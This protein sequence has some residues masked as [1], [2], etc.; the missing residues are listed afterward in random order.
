MQFCN[1]NVLADL[2]PRTAVSLLPGLPAYILMMC[3]RHT[4]Y[5]NDDD[6]V[7]SLLTAIINTV[8]KLIKKKHEDLD[9]TVLWLSN[10]LR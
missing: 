4:D 5:I 2:K 1:H 7:R 6:K 3:I 9:T 8:K 10:V